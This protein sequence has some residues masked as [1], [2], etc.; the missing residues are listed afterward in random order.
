M[1]LDPKGRTRI[2][3]STRQFD[4]VV[5]ATVSSFRIAPRDRSHC[6]FHISQHCSLTL[7]SCSRPDTI[8]SFVTEACLALS[9][10]ADIGEHSQFQK[11][12]GSVLTALLV[13]LEP[14]HG[15]ASFSLSPITRVSLPSVSRLNCSF[16][17]MHH[18]QKLASK[19]KLGLCH[20]SSCVNNFELGNEF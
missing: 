10:C 5:P 7:R 4:C 20:I 13:G 2:R 19:V 11:T 14:S 3:Q 9:I 17:R 15:L 8:R 12:I 16:S 1:N 18:P 6:I